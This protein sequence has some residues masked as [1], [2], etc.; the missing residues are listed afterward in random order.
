MWIGRCAGI[1]IVYAHVERKSEENGKKAP[2]YF[3]D[4]PHSTPSGPLSSLE[5]PRTGGEHRKVGDVGLR[6]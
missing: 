3:C 5:N 4:P 6:S 2:T 1:Y